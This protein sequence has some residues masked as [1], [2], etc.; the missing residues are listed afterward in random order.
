MAMRP[1][2]TLLELERLMLLSFTDSNGGIFQLDLSTSSDAGLPFDSKR[3]A[4]MVNG[5]ATIQFLLNSKARAWVGRMEVGPE[6]LQKREND[7]NDIEFCLRKL[8]GS[9]PIPRKQLNWVYS[10]RFWDPFLDAYPRMERIFKGAGIWQERAM[11]SSSSMGARNS[12]RSQ[13]S[14]SLTFDSNPASLQ[15]RPL[16]SGS[17]NRVASRSGSGR[18]HSA[19]GRSSRSNGSNGSGRPGPSGGSYY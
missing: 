13:F 10:K 6:Y 17:G 2:E 18:N 7:A 3:D 5:V 19:G 11:S 15:H 9:A 4:L 16:S 8:Q 14:G 1:L 12:S